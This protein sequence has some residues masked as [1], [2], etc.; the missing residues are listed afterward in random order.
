MLEP[1]IL[2]L[3]FAALGIYQAAPSVTTGDAGE[4]A[5]AAASWGVPHAPG[6]A[7]WTALAKALGTALPFG[8]W[9]YRANL[10]SALCAA[11]ALALLCDALRRWGAG[12]AARLGAVVILGLSPLWR[13]QSAV[14]EAFA[15]LALFA[16]GLLWLV[17]AAGERLLSPGPAAALGLVFGLG[18]G[19]H[20]T[21][22]LVLPALLL[23]GR[24]K[25]GSWPAALACAALGTVAGFSAHLAI[26][27]RALQSPPVDWGHA[28]TPSAFLRL[29][30]RRDY[31]T[32]ALTVEGARGFGPVE[33]G[34]QLWRFVRSS[35]DVLGAP[36]LLLA[37]VGLPGFLRAGLAVRVSVPAAWL[38]CAG[39]LF[40]FLGRPGF[41][42]QTSGALE[43]FSLL[44]LIG[45]VP[46][47]ASGLAVIGARVTAFSAYAA[48]IAAISMLP[49]A[50]AASRR[51][52]FLAYDYGRSI[53]RALPA[54]STL[55]MDGGDDTFYS[56]MHLTVSSGLRPD[57]V[58]HDRGGVVYP[59]GYGRD[60]RALSK[61]AKEA[62]RREVE[63][64]W[65]SSGR[66]WY[67]TLND[68][69]LPGA[70]LA[71][72]G[73]LRRPLASKADLPASLAL[74]ETTAVRWTPAAAEA[75]YRDRAL[76]A[77]M[78]Y[79][80]GVAAF[81][82]GETVEG[83]SWIESAAALAPDALWV[84]PTA[85]Y[86]LGMAGYGAV[87][88]KDWHGAER[89]YRAGAALE[90]AKAQPMVNLGVALERAGRGAEAETAFRE[91]IRREPA[92]A[93][94]WAAL[95]SRLWAE[96]R[97]ADAADAFDSAAA[98]EPAGGRSA[99]WAGQARARARAKR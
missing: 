85:S 78:P 45:L 56:L 79:Q 59:G 51:N 26:P 18:L 20:Q 96:E 89:A 19:V 97:W 29:L 22:V 70:V 76:A 34:A 68:N 31:G 55:V 87:E 90:P 13:E 39:P 63:A 64:R 23:A 50:L 46:F 1:L 73:L 81:S 52:D 42:A 30:L 24:G 43:R 3:V 40:L 25:K 92:S 4:F 83:V 61:E 17:A 91:A 9:A 69:L 35:V 62:R 38:F 36:A 10:L 33:L 11:A 57:V 65:F 37:G 49:D 80:R 84:V 28:V 48:L 98:L 75:R 72:A 47:I 66:L 8:D 15:P 41:D 93:P 2:F 21:L 88:R 44:P 99:A 7:T 27:L 95:G 94:A 60:F 5:A 12:R 71:P 67:S 14:A 77:F 53:L 82:R 32:F 58:L 16:A 74:D 54:S 6:Y 86:A